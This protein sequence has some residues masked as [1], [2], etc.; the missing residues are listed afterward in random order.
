M[1]EAPGTEPFRIKYLI[2]ILLTVKH[3]REAGK[4]KKH[5]NCIKP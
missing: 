5:E 3:R 2:L 1:T 4:K